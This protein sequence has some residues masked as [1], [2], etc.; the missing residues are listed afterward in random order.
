MSG[1]TLLTAAQV[2]LRLGR[3]HRWFTRNRAALE[4]RGFPGPVDGCG[5]RWDPVAIDG[6]L[7]GQLDCPPPVSD[8]AMEAQLLRRAAAMAR[9]GLSRGSETA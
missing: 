5:M 2:A 6:W 1:R 7:D 8:E 3:T 4:A 9:G